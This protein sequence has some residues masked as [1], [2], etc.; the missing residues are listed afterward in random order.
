MHVH[1]VNANQKK[2]IQKFI[3]FP[4]DLY[5]DNPYWVPPM[6]SDIESI[7]D[8]EKHPYYQHS[9]ADFFYV[10]DEGKVLAR[11]GAFHN[12]R[13]NEFNDSKTAF[14][15]YFESVN[16]PQVAERL[17][18]RVVVWAR[19]RGLNRLYGPKGALQG[20]G[21]GLLVKGFGHL[22]AMGIAYN[23]PYYDDLLRGVGFEKVADYYSGHL[24]TDIEIT[25]K[26]HR[27]AEKVKERRGFWVQKFEQVNEL[28]AIAPQIREVYNHAFAEGEGFNPI[29]EEEMELIAK[30]MLTIADPRLIKLV[31]KDEQIIGFLFSY[32]NIGEGLRKANGRL[33]P[34]GWFHIMRAFKTTRTVDINGMGILPEH[35][36]L[37]ATAVLYVELAKTVREFGF[38]NAEI[39][40][41]RE[42]N[43][44]SLG[45]AGIFEV[46]FHKIHR[47]YQKSL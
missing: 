10:E 47:V 43:R 21:I 46:D 24:D 13:Y 28:L 8:Q 37:G 35:Q 42:D 33:W 26:V 16:D 27:I 17:F 25:P 44:E 32:H 40:Q 39:V 36:G 19:E 22:P 11:I 1:Q 5:Q 12:K 30:K 7:F 14:F 41:I 20:D 29:T 9:E 2:D 45:E 18:D 23:L 4:F 34:L 38:E 6:R 31:Y 15:Y 3:Q